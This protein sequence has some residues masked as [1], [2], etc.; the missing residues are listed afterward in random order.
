MTNSPLKL[1][2]ISALVVIMDQLAKFVAESV[3]PLRQP[4]NVLPFFDWYLTYTTGA[5]F[6]FL[7]G[8]GGWQRWFFTDDD[9]VI[10]I[11]SN[12]LCIF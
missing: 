7:A 10:A 6:S 3:L 4:V 8:A 9:L 1:L 2:W 12:G 5:A 11:E